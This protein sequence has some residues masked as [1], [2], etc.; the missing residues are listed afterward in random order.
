VSAIGGARWQLAGQIVNMSSYSTL[1]GSNGYDLNV[2]WSVINIFVL[3]LAA[4]VC[5]ELPKRRRDARFLTNEPAV[6]IY[7]ASKEP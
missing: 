4:A 3:C 6:L 7:G 5:V 2:I 1:N